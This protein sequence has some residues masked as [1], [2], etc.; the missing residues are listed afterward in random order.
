[1][2]ASQ[3]VVSFQLART[4]ETL[5]AQ[6]GLAL[7]GEYLHGFGVDELVDCELPSPGSAA[8]YSPSGHVLPLVLMP[9]GGGRKLEDLRVLRRDEGL[10]ALLPQL[11]E[12][13]SS[14]ATGD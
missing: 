5:T 8:G 11:H 10:R 7:F 9:A 3:T 14:D 1:M 4:D 6:G 2:G 12:M 13:P